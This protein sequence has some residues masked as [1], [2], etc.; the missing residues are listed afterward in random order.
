[1]KIKLTPEERKRRHAEARASWRKRNRDRVRAYGRN[2][3]ARL[4]R[5]ILA[6]Y[7]GACACCGET[8]EEFLSFDHINGDGASHR[9]EIGRGGFIMAVWIKKNGFPPTIQLLCYN[10]N[11]SKGF[12]GYCPHAR[13]NTYLTFDLYEAA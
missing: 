4:R 7:G 6:R 12:R 13:R 1:M 5:E 11:C 10:C 9:R 2:F 3:Q 8:R